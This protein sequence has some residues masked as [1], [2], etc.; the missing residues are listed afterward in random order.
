MPS[1]DN[2]FVAIRA[3]RTT[4]AEVELDRRK[5]VGKLLTN[6]SFDIEHLE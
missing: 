6:K 4:E 2:I 1:E 5:A 3:I